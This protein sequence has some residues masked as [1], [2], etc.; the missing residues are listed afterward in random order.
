MFI[1]LLSGYAFSSVLN[2]GQLE[3]IMAIKKL[4]FMLA[5]L[6]AEKSHLPASEIAVTPPFELNHAS[7]IGEL[8]SKVI[9]LDLASE[10]KTKNT[11]IPVKTKDGD[12]ITSY[13]CLGNSLEF[14][15]ETIQEIN[16][17]IK[18]EN[19][20]ASKTRQILL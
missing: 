6:D 3:L 20:L 8:L 13:F 17:K 16:T 10:A 11:Y 18:G 14:L 9:R 19:N 7:T 15:K 1:T 12:F 2:I 4:P 5:I